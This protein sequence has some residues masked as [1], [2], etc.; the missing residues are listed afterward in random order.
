MKHDILPHFDFSLCYSFYVDQLGEFCVVW[1]TNTGFSKCFIIFYAHK[2]FN[3]YFHRQKYSETY[4]KRNL[5]GNNF[6]VRNIFL[7]SMYTG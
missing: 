3:L 2:M 6:C 4:Q 1:L 5:P 7:C